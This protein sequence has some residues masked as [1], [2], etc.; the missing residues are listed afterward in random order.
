[1]EGM[2]VESTGAVSVPLRPQ[3]PVGT[4]WTLTHDTEGIVTLNVGPHPH[5]YELRLILNNRFLRSRVH[6]DFTGVLDDAN[7]TRARFE[8][9]GFEELPTA[10]VH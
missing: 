10:T 8:E 4:L 7:D 2:R 5:G 1:M 3:T 9:L 6:R